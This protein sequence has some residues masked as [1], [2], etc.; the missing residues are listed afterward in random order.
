MI[1]SNRRRATQFIERIENGTIHEKFSIDN[2]GSI[3]EQNLD[4]AVIQ[5]DKYIV[6]CGYRL[7]KARINTNYNPYH[8]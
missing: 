7:L 8:G 1:P 4:N 5:F 6:S 2:N 3:Y